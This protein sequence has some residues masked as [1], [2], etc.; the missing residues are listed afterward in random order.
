[1]GFEW[2]EEN[3]GAVLLRYEGEAPFVEVPAQWNGLP[4]TEIGERAFADHLSLQE[5]VLPQTL[6]TVGDYAFSGCRALKQVALPEGVTEAGAHAFYNCRALY[7]LELPKKLRYV[8][9]GFLKNCDS[10]QEVVLAEEKPLSAGVVALLQNLDG[11]FLL[12]FKEKGFSLLFPGYDYEY[13]G[14]APAMRFYT[15]THGAGERYR[16]A[17]ETKGIDLKQYDQAFVI[18]LLEEQIPTLLE[19]VHHRLAHPYGLEEEYRRQYVMF[20]KHRLKECI[21]YADKQ[22]DLSFLEL[23][24]QEGVLNKET[25]REAVLAAAEVENSVISA[26]LLDFQMKQGG[27]RKKKFEL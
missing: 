21:A 4:V 12:T 15:I 10:L 11:R 5:V 2:K 26:F 9:D 22:G 16:R 13:A 24:E 3:G 8:G 25:A 27:L 23:M 20:C 18:G 1:M 6:R 7:H 17:I 14:N 19:L